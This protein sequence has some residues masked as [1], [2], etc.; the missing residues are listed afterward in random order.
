MFQASFQTNRSFSD[1][2]NFPNGFFEGNAFTDEQAALLEKH[3]HAY[4]EL[5]EGDRSP[6]MPLERQFFEFVVG[7]RV[8][9]NIHERTWLCYTSRTSEP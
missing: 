5:A 9:A 1:L 2:K 6:L 3:G 4:S 7:Q 8:P